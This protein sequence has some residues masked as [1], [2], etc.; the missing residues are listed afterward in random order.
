MTRMTDLRSERRR[1]EI[2][3]VMRRKKIVY[4]MKLGLPF[5]TED[6][7]KYQTNFRKTVSR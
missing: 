4:E 5:D 7:R 1:K 3:E 2:A 6:G